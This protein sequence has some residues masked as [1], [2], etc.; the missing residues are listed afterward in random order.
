MAV[1]PAMAAHPPTSPPA[2]PSKRVAARSTPRLGVARP[3]GAAGWIAG[4]LALLGGAKSRSIRS[5]VWV[6]RRQLKN[7][8]APRQVYY[9]DLLIFLALAEARSPFPQGQHTQ[10]AKDGITDGSGAKQ[11]GIGL[12]TE[13]ASTASE[14]RLIGSDLRF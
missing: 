13:Q 2:R 9:R 7:D 4:L 14:N 12:P 11:P 3:V 8:R 10:T 6:A 5:A 1:Q